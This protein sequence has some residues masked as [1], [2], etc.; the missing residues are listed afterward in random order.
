M[1]TG[2]TDR[3]DCEAIRNAAK[4]S[5]NLGALTY[6]KAIEIACTPDAV[7]EQCPKTCGVCK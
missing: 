4:T 3:D 1:T 7:K 6:D 2:C 5:A